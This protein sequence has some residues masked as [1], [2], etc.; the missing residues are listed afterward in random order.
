M[1]NAYCQVIIFLLTAIFVCLLVLVIL[2][3]DIKKRLTIVIKD[4]TDN[5][6]V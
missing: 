6:P 1:S 3:Y 4:I 5:L 2:L